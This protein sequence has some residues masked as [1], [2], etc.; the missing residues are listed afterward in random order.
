MNSIFAGLNANFRAEK[1]LCTDTTNFNGG[2]QVRSAEVSI[3]RACKVC[4]CPLV[5]ELPS[6][7]PLRSE[8]PDVSS[9]AEDLCQRAVSALF[10]TFG[11]GY[12]Q[13]HRIK[14]I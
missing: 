8:L 10:L 1:V 13:I 12:E 9:K 14:R 4:I 7:V 11:L 2:Y 5:L 6:K 3:G